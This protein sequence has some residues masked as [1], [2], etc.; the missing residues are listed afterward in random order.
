MKINECKIGFLGFG[1]MAQAI[2]KGWLLSDEIKSNQLYASAR[3]QDQLKKNTQELAIHTVSSNKELIEQVDLVILAVKPYQIETVLKPLIK[4]LNE[5]IVVSVAVNF[6]FEDFKK[7]LMSN[8]QHLSVLPN[9]PVAFNDGILLFEDKHSLREENYQLVEKL[10]R[11]VSHVEIISSKEMDI[12]GV[13]SGSAPAFVDLFI[14]A[15]ADAAVK[16]GLDR[17]TSYQLI[18][19]MVRGT[20]NLQ[21]KTGKHPG[22]LKDEIT[23]PSGTTIKGI[24]SLE[25]DAFRGSIIQAVDEILKE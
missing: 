16:H 3:N 2:A 9:T 14:E 25:K 7:I 24:A 22:Q 23:S 18:S 11:L 19:T 5:K 4:E 20:A 15:L 8:T 21:A 17:Q 6:L 13:I 10:F 12:A 1:N